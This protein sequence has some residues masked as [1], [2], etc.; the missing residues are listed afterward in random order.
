MWADQKEERNKFKE[1]VES[2]K[3]AILIT[4]TEMNQLKGRPMNTS[5][6]DNNG[7]LW[8]FSNEFSDQVHE[9]CINNAVLISYANTQTNNY[10]MVSGNAY[11]TR[12]INKINELYSPAIKTWFPGGLNDPNLLLIRVEPCEVEYWNGRSGKIIISFNSAPALFTHEKYMSG[13]Y[14]IA[15]VN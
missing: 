9:I 14:K 10:A 2:I 7:N 1:I 5:R 15:D 12:D 13:K 6:L 11:L 8:F 4:H 3:T